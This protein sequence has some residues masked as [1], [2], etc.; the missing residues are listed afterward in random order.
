MEVGWQTRLPHEV[1]YLQSHARGH[2]LLSKG[3]PLSRRTAEIKPKTV[4]RCTVS[5]HLRFLD[6]VTAKGEEY[7]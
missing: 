5:V 6:T 1:R 4:C 7:S 2:L 3:H